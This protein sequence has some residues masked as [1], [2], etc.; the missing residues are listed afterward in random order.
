MRRV[1]HQHENRL[2]TR[3]QFAALLGPPLALACFASV[4]GCAAYQVGTS[5]LYPSDITTVYVPVIRS[6]SFR[7]NLGEMLT[8]A[9]VKEIELKTPYKVVD[10]DVADSILSV[11]IVS[12]TKRIIIESPTDEGRDIEWQMV[13]L[14]SWVDRRGELLRQ[15][16]PIPVPN[17]FTQ[18]SQTANIVPE[19][20]SSIITAELDSMHRLAEQIVGLMEAPW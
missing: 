18:V 20:G 8:E 3:R 17:S 9:V 2:L 1:A 10:S 5:T 7:Y 12:D 6:T 13:A 14:V 19:V 16:S 11:E 15:G 4:T